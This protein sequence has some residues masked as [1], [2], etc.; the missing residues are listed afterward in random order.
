VNGA[1]INLIKAA[2]WLL[3]VLF[4]CGSVNASPAIADTGAATQQSETSQNL[5]GNIQTEWG[6]HIKVR[7]SVSWPEDGSYY[8]LTG[9]DTP[10]DGSIEGR[11]KN[12]LYFGSAV[13]LD[14]HYEMILSGGDTRKKQKELEHDFPGSALETFWTG[15][16]KDDRRLLDL[17]KTI[18][19][20]DD[21]VLYHRLDRLALTYQKERFVFRLGRQAVTWGNGFLFNPMDLFNP[22]APS[23][24]EREYKLGDDMAQAQIS[25]GGTGNVQLVYVPRRD[26]ETGDV[27]ADQ[28]TIAGKV[29]FAKGTT[30]FDLM[31]A[32]N[33]DDQ[34]I[35]AGC[36]GYLGEAAWRLD[37]TWTFTD[38]QSGDDDYLSLVANLDYSWVW[39]EKNFYGFVEVFYNGLG[40][41]AYADDVMDAYIR[42]QIARGQLFTLGRY[43]LGGHVRMEVH[44]LV[45]VFLTVI[46]NLDDPSGMLQPRL[47]WDITEDLQLTCGG[48]VLYGGRG[49]EYGGFKVPPSDILFKAPDSAYMWLAWYF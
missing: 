20:R 18:T 28:N 27:E 47:T 37:A 22:F 33:F 45:N 13:Y 31:A 16:V 23:D 44:P 24:I 6:G 5:F 3:V 30:E 48:N 35:G 26:P 12:R 46:H 9:T 15:E 7:G 4:I 11:L 49:T 38:E 8:D 1:G 14:T 42:D 41:D 10:F 32:Q 43:Y 25:F 21:Y 19:D 29:H 36:T 40:E 17:S 39:W 34:V 2:R